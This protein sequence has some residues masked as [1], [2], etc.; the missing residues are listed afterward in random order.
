[1]PTLDHWHEHGGMVA[2]GVLIDYKAWYEQKAIAEG[3][4]GPDAIC[5]PFGGHRITVADIEV[6][7]KDQN[8]EF[9][10]GDVLIIRTGATD[11]LSAPTPY[12][13]GMM[14]RVQFS[15]V[16]GTMATAKWLWNK[17]F[18]AVAGDSIA[19]EALPPLKEN[20]EPVEMADLG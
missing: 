18:S 14:Q 3:K 16:A 17:H 5:H 11:V 8:V 4:S 1:M 12:D 6:I 15:G 20:G 7:A 19:F 13:L 10:A 9:R 2:R